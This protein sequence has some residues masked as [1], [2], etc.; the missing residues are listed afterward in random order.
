[1]AKRTD[2]TTYEYRRKRARFLAESDVC[3]LC[4][5]AGADVV[6]HDRPVARGADPK[7][8]DNWRPAHGVNRCPTCGRNCNGEKGA[9]AR[10][11]VGLK[12]S[13]DWYT[14]G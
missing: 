10:S 14:G 5:H 13:R 7:D 9:R 8:M 6:D 1:M 2:L 3:H 12:T 11:T 4:G